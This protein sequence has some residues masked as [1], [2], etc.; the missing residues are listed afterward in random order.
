MPDPSFRRRLLR[1]WLAAAAGFCALPALAGDRPA[2]Q[3]GAQALKDLIAKVLPVSP[4]GQALVSVKPDGTAYVISADLAAWNAVMRAAGA[5]ASYDPA[6][7]VYR[8]TEQDDG[9]WRVTQDSLPTITSRAGEVVSTVEVANFRQTMTI[10]PTIAWW[11]GGSA[12]ADKGAIAV[13]GPGF[14]QGFAF[15]PA[16]ADYATTVKPDGSVSTAIKEEVSDIDVKAAMA[17]KQGDPANVSAQI[18]KAA[19]NVGADGLKSRKL[20]DLWMLVA[21]GR[22]QLASREAE[23]KG[24]LREIA[25]PGL[26]FAEGGEA[27][28]AVIASPVGAIALADVKAAFGLANAGPE[29][30]LDATLSLAGLSLPV[31]LAPPGAADLTPSLVDVTATF[32][33]FDFA[34]AASAAIDALK[35][36]K[37]GVEIP[38]EDGP[39]VMAALL[40]PGPLRVDVAPSHIL[41]PAIDADFQGAVRYAVGK[42]SG[43][44]TIRVRHFDKTMAAIKG[45]GPEIQLQAMPA[46][47]M[48]KGLAKADGDGTLSWVVE[49]G[50]DRSI[51]VNGIPLGR[52]PG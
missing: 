26:K 16:K 6:V 17:G 25:A 37:D 34:A 28:K 47:A 41:A 21:V 33:G 44:M 27:T 18:E 8:A 50:E 10:D 32:K 43:Q 2:T 23:L 29:R 31:G 22:D 5:T 24:L 39:K 14:A 35:V 20:F 38:D 4:E 40:G 13:K 45:L 7:L 12:S 9:K 42:A 49:L 3:Q 15:G 48:A 51:K 46:I 36:T 30:A 11:T 1:A 19:F 52:A